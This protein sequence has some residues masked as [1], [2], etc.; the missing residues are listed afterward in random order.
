MAVRIRFAQ[1]MIV[2]LA[3]TAFVLPVFASAGVGFAQATKTLNYRIPGEPSTIDPQVASL[4]RDAD[5]INGLWRGLLRYDEKNNPVPSIA[6]EVP[7]VDNGGISADGKTY[8]YH[9]RQDWKWSDGNGVV[10]AKDFVYAF[11]RLVNPKTASGY[12][13]FLDGLLLNADT[14]NGTDAAKVDQTLLDTLGVKAP[15]DFTVQFSLVHPASYFNQI[16]CM[17]IGYAVRQDN[18]ER[19]GD[20]ASGAWTDPVNGPVV[21]SGPFI[22]SKWDHD[23][24]IVYDRNPNFSGSAAKLDSIS[25]QLIQ[26]SSVSY[27]GYKTGKLDVAGYP[28]AE[29]DAIVKDKALGKQLLKYNNTCENYIALDNTKAPFDN[30]DVRRAFAYATDRDGYNT[31]IARKLATKWLSFIPPGIAGADPT[32]GAN[33]DY[34]PAKAKAALSKAGY[35][36]GKGFPP[37]MF[38]YSAG[39]NGQ[40]SADWLQLQYKKILNVTIKLDPMDGA[41]L[42]SSLSDLKNKVDGMFTY[43]WC[44]DYLHPSDWLNPVFNSGGAVGNANNTVGFSD[45]AFDKLATQADSTVDDAAALKLYQ[46]AQQ[47]LI[48]D[49]PVIFMNI[50]VAAPLVNPRVLNL[51]TSDLDGGVPGGYFWEDIDLAS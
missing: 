47:V 10:K 50:G 5:L 41:A 42:A 31:V 13:S 38:H 18:V 34:N 45:P 40:Q 15:D 39:A 27:A 33:Y 51:K 16:A 17:W 14:I 21:G 24:Q 35:P 29:Y 2:A 9:L 26:D 28:L 43:G 46:Q 37:V 49:V 20:P 30:I 23:K 8:T 22:I 36:N 6:K 12:G 11:Q 32:L 3:V 25:F 7:T 44:A 1:P 19:A 4:T 48:D